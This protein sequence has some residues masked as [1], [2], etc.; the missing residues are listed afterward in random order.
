MHKNVRK[1]VT[2]FAVL[3]VTL[4]AS[5]GHAMDADSRSESSASNSDSSGSAVDR[6][7][8]GRVARSVPELD[9]GYALVA[10]GLIA[11]LVLVIRERRKK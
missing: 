4:F 6:Q 11:G 3:G 1:L 9:G 8:D 7:Y 10:M 5:V 2:F